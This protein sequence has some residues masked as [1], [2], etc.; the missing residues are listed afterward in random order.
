[1][2]PNAA[3]VITPHALHYQQCVD[4]IE[5]GCHVL[6]E[7]PMVIE[8]GHARDL[9]A[10]VRKSGKKLV[11]G[12]CPPFTGQFAYLRQA[13]RTKALGELE[14]V[15]GYM[16]QA[17]MGSGDAAKMGWRG[18]PKLSGGGQAYDSGA[19]Q[20]AALCWPVESPV[21]EVF[22]FL[23]YKGMP[24]DVNSSI[25]VRFE[26]GVLG[27]VVIGGN[28]SSRG[29]HTCFLF[30]KGRIEIDG[31]T[32][33][34]INVFPGAARQP[35][36]NVEFP[37]PGLSPAENFVDAVCGRAEPRTTAEDGV[38]QSELM[39]AIYEAARTGQMVRIC[40]V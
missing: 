5:S 28:C 19:H 39:E 35:L 2:K 18:D 1:L 6:V 30:T 40:R 9:A 22:A 34:W 36:E 26:N 17:W 38:V 13:I 23:D 29:K 31:W 33:N 32:G 8:V 24:V 11:I 7:K 3:A 27:N 10:R 37:L 21:A 15:C 20:L 4:A 14:L 25:N 16:S 12:Y